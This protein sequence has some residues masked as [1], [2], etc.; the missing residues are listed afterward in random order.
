[1]DFAAKFRIGHSYDEFLAR[2]ATE[3]QKRRWDAVHAEVQL[4]EAQRAL[5]RGFVREMKVL[6]VSGAWCG[7]CIEQLPIFAHFAAENPKIHIQYFDRD[8]H[9]DLADAL[10]ICG[11]RRVPSVLFLSEDN[12]P[13][14]RAGD[15]TLA[16]YRHIAASQLGAACSTGISPPGGELLTQV[17]QDWLGEFERIQLMLRTSGRLRQLHGD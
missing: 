11:G 3:E 1:M 10:S 12:F 2:Y 16:R 15:R 7:D 4:T 13:C 14:G 17:T 9:P 6:V 8:D 5:L